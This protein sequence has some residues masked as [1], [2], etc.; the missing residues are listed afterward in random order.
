MIFG[1]KNGN[2]SL[3]VTE[4]LLY[5]SHL[6]LAVGFQSNNGGVILKLQPQAKNLGHYGCVWFL[7][8]LKVW[9]EI[10]SL[11]LVD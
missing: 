8:K 10:G 5:F 9:V 2:A 11:C 3:R 6:L 7:P 4:I 1:E